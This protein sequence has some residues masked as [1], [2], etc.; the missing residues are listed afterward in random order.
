M[1]TA[2]PMVYRRVFV[3]ELPVRIFHWVNALCIFLLI[4]TGYL[5]GNP[6]AIF[7]ANEPYQQYWFGWVRFTHFATAYV[8]FFNFLFRVYWGFVGNRFARWSNFVPVKKEQ[9]RDLWETIRIDILQLKLQG[10][11][12]IGHNYLASLTYIGLFLIFIFQVITGFGM[13]ASMSG[14]YLP[15]MFA[16]IIP[17]MGSDANVR[18]WHHLIMWAFVVFTIIHVYLVFYHDWVEG[19]G[20]VS[21][22][23]GG[24]KFEKDD[25]IK[26]QY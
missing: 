15:Q 9:W 21:S 6:Q 3:W 7:S 11:I 12:S 25:D 18:I 2:E 19:R 16:W 8:V 13:Y 22:I 17:L 10:K 26:K 4:A 5:I 23:I 14:A 24:W 1:A 20:D